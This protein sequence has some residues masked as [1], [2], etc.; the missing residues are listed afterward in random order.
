MIFAHT[1]VGRHGRL[2]PLL[3]V[4]HHGGELG[5][6]AGRAAGPRPG[7]PGGVGPGPQAARDPR[8]TAARPVPAQDQPRRAAAAA[9]RGA[10]RD[11]PG[12]ARG[13]WCRTSSS[14]TARPRSTTSRSA[15]GLT[16][17]WQISGRNDL[18]YERRVAL[19]AWY[20]RNWT[21]WYDIL[22]LFR[23]LARRPRQRQRRLLSAGY[24]TSA[25]LK[26]AMKSLSRSPWIRMWSLSAR[27]A[28][29]PSPA[30]I[31]STTA[32]CSASEVATRLRARSCSRR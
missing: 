32:W 7:G 12:R 11:E 19:D 10:R 5:R 1:R 3:Q 31:A 30:R 2:F 23:T 16:G 18:D 22:I 4:P 25:A 20:V 28:R 26:V 29:S 6:G 24:A 14:S 17:L 8:I 27:S 13:R 9:Q 15:P 21:L